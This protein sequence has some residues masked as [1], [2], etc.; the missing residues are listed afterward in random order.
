MQTLSNLDGQGESNLEKDSTTPHDANLTNLSVT[1]ESS[2]KGDGAKLP[3]T[4]GI[5]S[6]MVALS[7]SSF[8]LA[9]DGTVLS[10]VREPSSPA[11]FWCAVYARY[12]C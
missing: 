6:L 1:I 3:S 7:V 5:L 8:L 12:L 4:L 2:T 10:T 11:T 9:M